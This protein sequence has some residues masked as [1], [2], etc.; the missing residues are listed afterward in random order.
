[1]FNGAGPKGANANVGNTMKAI[2]LRDFGSP[3]VLQMQELPAPAIANDTDV[4][5]R[6]KA[7]GVNPLDTKLRAKAGIYPLQSPIVLGCD[8]AGVV[9]AVGTAV[10][11]FKRGD[12]VFFYNFALHG[13]TG[14]YAQHT[15]VDECLLA[16][17]PKSLSFIEA[18]AVPLSFITAWEALHERCHVHANNH[19][20]IHAGAGGVGHIAV[21]LA[22][23][24]G[25]RVATTVGDKE[26]SDFVRRLGADLPILYKTQDFVDATL[27]FTDHRGA[28]IA[29]DTVGGDTFARCFASV[30]YGGDVVTLL[31]PATDTNWGTARS[32][33]LRVS[34]ELILAPV[35]LGLKAAQRHQGLMLL[36]ATE[37]IDAGKLEIHIG[38]TY[39][40]EKAA[41]AHRRIEAG[42]VTGKLVLTID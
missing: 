11:R 41:D 24:A 20:L 6:L 12:E 18:A 4:L 9:E 17:K 26:K 16:R 33:N 22:K 7:A 5:V 36:E 35:V 10:K 8:G 31:A 40:L 39:P 23:Q 34:F 15:V 13:R 1:L 2:V 14:T 42:G 19:V 30:R 3:D 21:Q 29:F 32:R 38:E 28:D 37:L 25:A 27:A